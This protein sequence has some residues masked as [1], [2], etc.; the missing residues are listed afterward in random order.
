MG[1]FSDIL[2]YNRENIRVGELDPAM[3]QS[4]YRYKR[5]VQVKNYTRISDYSSQLRSQEQKR[6][7]EQFFTQN[8]AE[9]N[10]AKNSYLFLEKLILEIINRDIIKTTAVSKILKNICINVNNSYRGICELLDDCIKYSDVNNTQNCIIDE[11]DIKSELLSTIINNILG[12]IKYSDTNDGEEAIFRN[13]VYDCA[14]I[15]TYL[16]NVQVDKAA[17]LIFSEYLECNGIY[18]SKLICRN[19]GEKLYEGIDYCLNCYE[20]DV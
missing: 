14:N 19:C 7:L 20:R 13:I 6:F 12:A 1:I 8:Y 3:I 2:E 10:H 5:G 11:N 17:K 15:I 9:L 4:F 18:K 16:E